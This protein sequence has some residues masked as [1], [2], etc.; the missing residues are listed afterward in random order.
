M[1]IVQTRWL[2][3]QIDVRRRVLQMTYIRKCTDQTADMV[4]NHWMPPV[5]KTNI[6]ILYHASVLATLMN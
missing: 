3:F 5:T 4:G 6:R 1:K 2:A